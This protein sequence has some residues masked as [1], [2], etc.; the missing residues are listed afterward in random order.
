MDRLLLHLL[1]E[2]GALD[3]VGEARVVLDIGGDGELTAGLH[4]LDHDRFKHR[5]RRIDRG[6]VAGGP[7]AD[8]DDFGLGSFGHGKPLRGMRPTN[9][10][11]FA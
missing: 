3:D 8:N 10:A 1:H 9:L 6:G 4:A 7:G 2:P 5:A 11:E